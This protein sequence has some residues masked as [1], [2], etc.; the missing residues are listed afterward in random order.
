MSKGIIL[1]ILLGFLAFGAVFNIVLLV[2]L[3]VWIGRGII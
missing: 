1:V 2:C 3:C